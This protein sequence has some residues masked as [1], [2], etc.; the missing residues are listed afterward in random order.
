MSM[1]SMLCQM[2]LR[3]FQKSAFNEMR[4]T[5]E[6]KYFLNPVKSTGIHGK[7]TCQ[8]E[9]SQVK[10]TNFRGYKDETTMI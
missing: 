8:M 6:H 7:E 2:R 1:L 3:D 5:N 10:I 9:I 4:T